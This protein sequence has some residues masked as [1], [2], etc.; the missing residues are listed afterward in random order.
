MRIVALL[1]A[2]AFMWVASACHHSP[3]PAVAVQPQVDSAAIQAERARE[4]QD[5]IARAEAEARAREA[6]QR[7]EDS[8]A[9][10]RRRSDELK[11]QL[12]SLIHFDFD[13]SGIRAGDAQLGP[14]VHCLP[15]F[16]HG[17]DPPRALA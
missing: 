7:R 9:A 3:P 14:C 11:A 6:A 12:A 5:S 13:K 16:R 1:L 17:F 10:L 15:S 8:I 4:R 2:V